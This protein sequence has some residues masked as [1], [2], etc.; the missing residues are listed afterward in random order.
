MLSKTTLNLC[1]WVLYL[2]QSYM[3]KQHTCASCY[4]R[5]PHPNKYK[6]RI[7]SVLWM[8]GLLLRHLHDILARGVV[9]TGAYHWVSVFSGGWTTWIRQK[10]TSFRNVSARDVNVFIVYDVNMCLILHCCYTKCVGYIFRH[11]QR[12]A[13]R[14]RNLTISSRRWHHLTTPNGH[15]TKVSGPAKL[16]WINGLESWRR[17][18]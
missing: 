7:L 16:P 15:L 2:K 14:K 18:F 5:S 8:V 17:I 6:Y 11:L 9:F 12:W 10:I 13:W 1:S 4:I 3:T